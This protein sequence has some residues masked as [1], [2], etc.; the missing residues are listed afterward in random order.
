MSAEH[1]DKRPRSNSPARSASSDC[2]TA[3]FANLVLRRAKKLSDETLVLRIVRVENRVASAH[4]RAGKLVLGA[5]AVAEFES[6]LSESQMEKWIPQAA[7]AAYSLCCQPSNCFEVTP[8]EFGIGQRCQDPGGSLPL[9]GW[10]WQQRQGF[11]VSFNGERNL[12]TT[13]V[14]IAGLAQKRDL[15]VDFVT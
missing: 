3:L 7:R 1:A 12:A 10:R 15:A 4:E 2:W 6:R 14:I 13:E 5:V 8:L 11:L 9:F